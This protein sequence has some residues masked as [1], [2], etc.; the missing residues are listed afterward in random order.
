MASFFVECHNV[1]TQYLCYNMQSKQYFYVPSQGLF[2]QSL[3]MWHDIKTHAKLLPYYD[4]KMKQ[5]LAD[6]CGTL[7]H[8]CTFS[9]N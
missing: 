8:N 5:V 3:K 9:L 6:S 7:S 2:L 1:I 4:D